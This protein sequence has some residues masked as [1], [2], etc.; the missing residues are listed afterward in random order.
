[1]PLGNIGS[2]WE[3][4]SWQLVALKCTWLFI[5]ALALTG[6]SSFPPQ[7]PPG[8]PL[9]VSAEVPLEKCTPISGLYTDAGSAIGDDG[10]NLGAVSLTRIV[11][12]AQPPAETADMVVVR[13]PEHDVIEVESFKG[14]KSIAI[15]KKQLIK[16]IYEKYRPQGYAC[17]KG[18]IPFH[19]G[20]QFAAL[21]PMPIA[22][23]SGEELWLRKAIDGS[24]IILHI[25]SSGGLVILVPWG[26][27]EVTWYRFL[28]VPESRENMLNSMP[29]ETRDNPAR[30]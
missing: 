25:K 15:L 4:V 6:C 11:N 26:S 3:P 23:Y 28:P 2:R 19:I 10:V 27:S 30:P 20:S 1:M 12:L 22:G 21:S 16:E 29:Q 5:I 9:L 18:F 24:L 14:R 8:M 13:G 17:T 7:Y